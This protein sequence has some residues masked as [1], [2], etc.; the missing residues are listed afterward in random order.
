[1]TTASYNAPE[2]ICTVPGCGLPRHVSRYGKR[3]HRCEEHEKERSSKTTLKKKHSALAPPVHIPAAAPEKVQS[4]PTPET[5]RVMVIDYQSQRLFHVVGTVNS[6][7]SFPPTEGD[8]KRIVAIASQAGV[9]VAYI[10]PYKNED[11][12][13]GN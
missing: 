6:A 1:M 11:I 10:R 9:Y 5:V 4:E 13:E 8:M 3:Y 2:G 7:D 12:H